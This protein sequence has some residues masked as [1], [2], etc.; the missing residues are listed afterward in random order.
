M[1]AFDEMLKD[2][3]AAFTDTGSGTGEEIVITQ[4]G[5]SRTISATVERHP[6]DPNQN[7]HQGRSVW[8]RVSIAN[9][10]VLGASSI[11]RLKD[12]ITLALIQ[13]GTAKAIPITEIMDQ[14][15]GMWHLKVGGE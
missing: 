8:A 12:T 11:N 5:V 4:A 13:G 2:D 15:A 9:D 6:P 1:G 14:D 10:A 3:A 7:G